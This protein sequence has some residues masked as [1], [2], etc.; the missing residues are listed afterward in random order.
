LLFI[1]IF[2]LQHFF[3]WRQTCREDVSRAQ[4]S[5]LW[6]Q[7]CRVKTAKKRCN[8]LLTN[9]INTSWYVHSNIF[10]RNLLFLE[11]NLLILVFIFSRH[12]TTSWER[13]IG[14]ILRPTWISIQICGWRQDHQVDQIEIRCTDSPTL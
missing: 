14:M 7:T 13:Y 1:N 6:R 4:W 11:L 8:I 12:I 3:V 2:N 5:F 10:F 9:A